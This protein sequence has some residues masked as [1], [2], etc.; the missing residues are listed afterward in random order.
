MESAPPHLQTPIGTVLKPRRIILVGL[1]RMLNDIVKKVIT[2]QPDL[3]VVAELGCAGDIAHAV[4]ERDADLVIADPSCTDG[5]IERL[6]GP[7]SRLRLLEVEASGRGSCLS[8]LRPHRVPLGEIS[9]DR[10]LGAIRT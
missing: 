4:A 9:P 7:R 2:E 6:V 1:P 3:E 5:A 8:E 10:L